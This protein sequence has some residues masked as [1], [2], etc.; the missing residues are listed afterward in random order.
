MS[1]NYEKEGR[2]FAVIK[3]GK[4]KNKIVSISAD[5]DELIKTYNKIDIK[6]DGVFQQIPDPHPSL[7]REIGY[8]T[9][10]SGAGK[11]TYVKNYCMQWRKQHKENT[12]Y[13]FSTLGEDSS[14][15]DIKPSRVKI[16][17][18]LISDPISIN[19]F[20]EESLIIFDDIDCISNKKIRDELYNIM[21]KI[22][23]IGRHKKLYCLITNHMPTMGKD[24]KRILNECHF[25]VYFP[26]SGANGVNM[27]RLL[28]DYL[29][30][31]EK[32]IKKIKKMPTRWCTIFKHYPSFVMTEKSVF[33]MDE[34][35]SDDD[36]KKK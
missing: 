13:L 30:L 3:G 24:S 7:M 16:D 34:D 27:K 2:P 36:K 20:E 1:F 5:S 4:D 6:D 33:V 11:T 32:T 23:E 28:K 29:G 26:K 35:E 14:L 15:D 21:N 19:D 9:A 31:E 17:E 8:I 18:T 12:I 22:L 10:P 25:V